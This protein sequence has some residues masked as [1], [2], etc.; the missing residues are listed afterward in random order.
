MKCPACNGNGFIHNGVTWIEADTCNECD[1]DGEVITVKDLIKLLS[2]MPQDMKVVI[3]VSDY[4][5]YCDVKKVGIDQ[6]NVWIGD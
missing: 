3:G 6:D 4:P 1:G 5:V 2:N